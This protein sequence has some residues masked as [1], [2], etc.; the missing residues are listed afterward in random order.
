MRKIFS[1]VIL[2]IVFFCLT[3]NFEAFAKEEVINFNN[4]ASNKD[5]ESLIK[6][7]EKDRYSVKYIK[8]IRSLF[9]YN[10]EDN[11]LNKDNTIKK[12]KK[13]IQSSGSS[14]KVSPSSI[15][16]DEFK[17]YNWFIKKIMKTEIGNKD[18]SS[19]R[20]GVIDSGVDPKNLNI[21]RKNSK[22]Y[23]NNNVDIT[24]NTGHGTMVS[25]MI[26][27][28]SPNA[29]ISIYKV[30]DKYEGD[31]SDIIEAIVDATKDNDI[32]NISLGTY[33]DIDQN[34]DKQIIDLYGRAINYANNNNSIIVASAGN[35]GKNL[36]NNNH[37]HLPGGHNDVITV[38]STLKNDKVASYSN[39][40]D[41]LDIVAPGGYFGEE[42]DKNQN[43]NV[44]D[45]II[46]KFPEYLEQNIVDKA[47]G[48]KKGY[49]LNY[50][51]SI[52]TPQVTA[53]LVRLKHDNDKLNQS[54]IEKK[55][56]RNTLDIE[57]V[58]KDS[59]SGHG[60][61]KINY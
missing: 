18:Y 2:F 41:N 5:I 32:I 54:E 16:S 52:S 61:L 22:N 48:L 17:D 26:N 30:I 40:G 25:N 56:Y 12:Y 38:G 46:T 36:L 55:L 24:D 21:E 57:R 33:K 49:S 28:I 13:I 14:F 20:V 23:I 42:F 45:M 50:G 10:Y 9:I 27:T 34:R 31:S 51:T 59:K 44:K 58:G 60:L 7:L 15:A 53:A 37:M 35:D 47:L 39:F 4:K 43:I 11:V 8:E 3:S 19:V 6:E 29:R 1:I